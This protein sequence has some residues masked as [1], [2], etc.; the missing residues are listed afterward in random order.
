MSGK[1]AGQGE[2]VPGKTYNHTSLKL[3]KRKNWVTF[4]SGI[5]LLVSS[6]DMQHF[7]FSVCGYSF[8]Y[9]LS[10]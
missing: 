9:E 3:L 5:E 6:V 7:H 4:T 2:E 8:V 10:D 1:K